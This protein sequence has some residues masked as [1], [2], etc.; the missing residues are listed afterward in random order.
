MGNI[1]NVK[2]HFDKAI[3][4]SLLTAK[5]KTLRDDVVNTTKQLIADYESKINELKVSSRAEEEKL[6]AEIERLRAHYKQQ[7]TALLRKMSDY[8]E[9]IVKNANKQRKDAAARGNRYKS[10]YDKLLKA[11]D[12]VLPGAKHLI[13]NRALSEQEKQ[14]RLEKLKGQI[15]AQK[16]KVGDCV[17]AYSYKHSDYTVL[18]GYG[19][20]SKI[21]NTLLRREQ[22]LKQSLTYDAVDTN[23]KGA[24]RPEEPEQARQQN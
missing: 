14:Q 11:I 23:E 15:A 10:Q 4:G 1:L 8:K 18:P 19:R 2:E 7:E 20:E 24:K 21:L 16:A 9:D 3:Q 22:R 6:N 13:E 5:L 17:G 12:T